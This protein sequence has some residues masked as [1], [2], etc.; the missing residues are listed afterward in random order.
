MR[1]LL[2]VG[3]FRAEKAA[4]EGMIGVAGNLHGAAIF[5]R[6]EHGARIGAIMRAGRTHNLQ[7]ALTVYVPPQSLAHRLFRAHVSFT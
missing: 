3:Y 7:C 5:H 2:V 6:D 4:R 1:A